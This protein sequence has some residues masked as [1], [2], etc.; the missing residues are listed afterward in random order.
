MAISELEEVF[1]VSVKDAQ[2]VE[3]IFEDGFGNM[4]IRQVFMLG[5]VAGNRNIWDMTEREINQ[6]KECGL[7]K[8]YEFREVALTDQTI[9]DIY[10]ELKKSG[11][12]RK[13]CRQFCSLETSAMWHPIFETTTPGK[14]VQFEEGVTK[15]LTGPRNAA[16]YS[17]SLIRDVKDKIGMCPNM[18]EGNTPL[19]Y[20]PLIAD[21]IIALYQQKAP[22]RTITDDFKKALAKELVP[23]FL[24]ESLTNMFE[25]D[26][27]DWSYGKVNILRGSLGWAKSLAEES[28][29]QL[30]PVYQS[31]AHITNLVDYAE[32]EI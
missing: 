16:F 11:E 25:D 23:A 3:G 4:S 21:N 17:G 14:K 22:A 29:I 32:R 20:M 15:N 30:P 5:L 27:N 31:M 9:K 24:A 6:A 7:L 12:L 13:A 1:A 28:G 18:W 8:K 10:K 2:K 26:N 19:E